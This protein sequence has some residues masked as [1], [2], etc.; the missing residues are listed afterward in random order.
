MSYYPRVGYVP[1]DRAP[2]MS[3]P[4]VVAAEQRILTFADGL[5]TWMRVT[6]WE[7]EKAARGLHDFLTHTSEVNPAGG[8]GER[9]K[10]H[11]LDRLDPDANRLFMDLLRAGWERRCWKAY[12]G[13]KSEV[14]RP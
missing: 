14:E 1:G 9:G 3:R 10:I 11:I 8:P 4:E 12:Y 7:P 5:V 6:P 2:E 13:E